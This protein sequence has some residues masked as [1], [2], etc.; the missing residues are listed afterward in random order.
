MLVR[1][2]AKTDVSLC[3][4]RLAPATEMGV[5]FKHVSLSAEMATLVTKEQP[6]T[7]DL[8]TL[9]NEVLRALASRFSKT[10]S[11]R[12][13]LL[14][15]VTGSFRPGAMTLSGK[16]ALMK[17]LSGRFPMD[18]NTTLQ[19]DISYNGVPR[20]T[21]LKRLP[22]F[23][24]FVPQTDTH[25]PALTVRE[26]V[27]FAHECCGAELTEDVEAYLRR[28]SAEENAVAVST[29][30]TSSCRLWGST[31]VTEHGGGQCF[32]SWRLRRRE[33]A[34]DGRRDGV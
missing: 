19:G 4:C 6:S 26:T 15:D 9:A 30:Q 10:H 8:P 22:Q 1:R 29:S 34:H 5:C 31:S 11:V 18:G 28:G 3:H 24:N 27:E 17:L 13:P 16:S 23:V 32:A 25:L 21:L 2:R 33:E 14:Q 7:S 12:K 20:E